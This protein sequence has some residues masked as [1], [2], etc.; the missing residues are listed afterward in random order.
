M[1]AIANGPFWKICGFSRDHAY[2]ES[3]RSQANLGRDTWKQLMDLYDDEIEDGM[4]S[5]DFWA[6]VMLRVLGAVI[7]PFW[8]LVGLITFGWLWPPQVRERLLSSTVF[9]HTTDMAKEDEQRKTQIAKLQQEVSELKEDIL[10][11]L[12]MDRTH[13]MQLRSQVAERK[14]EIA[15]EMRDIKRLLALLFE[16]QADL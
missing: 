12:A 4:M 3:A 8:L 11:E 14:S 9:A 5:F 7:I 6:H 15:A 13:V 10:Q 1:D 2:M 16:R